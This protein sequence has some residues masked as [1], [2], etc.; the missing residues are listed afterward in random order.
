MDLKI[1]FQQH[2]LHLTLY[3]RKV[4]VLICQKLDVAIYMEMYLSVCYR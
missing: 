4:K 1:N 2:Y 3:Q